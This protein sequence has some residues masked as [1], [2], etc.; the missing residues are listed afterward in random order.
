M[1]LCTVFIQYLL[2]MRIMFLIK[3]VHRDIFRIPYYSFKLKIKKII[4]SV[5]LEL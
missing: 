5:D 3:M 1:S 2:K 4:T